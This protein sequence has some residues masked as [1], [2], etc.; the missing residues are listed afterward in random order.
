MCDQVA[1]SPVVG[2]GQLAEEISDLKNDSVQL[3]TRP[4]LLSW[5]VVLSFIISL[6][7]YHPLALFCQTD[8]IVVESIMDQWLW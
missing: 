4:R 5:L 3:H 6:F 1:Q 7:H 8:D 2:W